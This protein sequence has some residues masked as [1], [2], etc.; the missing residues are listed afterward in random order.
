MTKKRVI[1]V[2]VSKLPLHSPQAIHK[3]KLLAGPRWS[4]R[5]PRDAGIGL[6][7][8]KRVGEHGYIKISCEDFPKPAMN[9]KWGSDI[10]DNMLKEANVRPSHLVYRC[11]VVYTSCN[12]TLMILLR[13]YLMIN[14]IS[15]R[16]HENAARESMFVVDMVLG[17]PLRTFLRTGY[18]HIRK[19]SLHHKRRRNKL[20]AAT[21]CPLHYSYCTV[22][23]SKH[24]AQDSDI[25]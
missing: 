21:Y 4:D 23:P 6:E 25:N 3:L 24:I 20:M 19:T 7:E 1:V 18:L 12:R 5:P 9:L 8:D 10:L 16:K 2:A 11:V 22:Y 15:T 13:T 17:Q 14:G